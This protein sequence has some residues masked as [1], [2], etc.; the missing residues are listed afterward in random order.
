MLEVMDWFERI[1]KVEIHLHLEGAIPLDALWRLIEKYGGD[2]SVPD[3]AALA[4]RFEYRDFPHFIDTWLWK[5]EFLREYEDFTWI[6]EAVAR[7]LARQNVRYLEAFYSPPDFSHHGLETQRL[8]EAVRSGLSRV[9]I[10]RRH[11]AC[12]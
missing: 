3:P 6:A 1:P 8:T 9:L 11:E 5:N 2:P 4:R 10:A 12:R 7:D